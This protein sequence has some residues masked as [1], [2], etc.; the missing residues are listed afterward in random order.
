MSDHAEARVHLGIVV[1]NIMVKQELPWFIENGTLLGAWRDGK[2]IE[3]DDDFDIA[4]L[5]ANDKACANTTEQLL[6]TWT[7]MREIAKLLQAHL[8]EPYKVREVSSYACK[9]EVFD[10]TKGSRELIGPQYKGANF[11]NVTVDIQ[12]YFRTGN[13]Y[14]RIYYHDPRVYDV[15]IILPCTTII[16]HDESFPAPRQ[17]REWLTL[18]YGCLDRD[19]KYNPA[20]LRYVPNTN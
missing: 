9:L 11:H 1:R 16:F 8:P 19:A 20:T 6:R 15:N 4:V 5:C 13:K 7:Q 12:A 10:P 17:T 2:S 18:S 14:E 3:G